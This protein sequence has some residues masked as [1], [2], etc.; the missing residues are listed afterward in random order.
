MEMVPT[1]RLR[2]LGLAAGVLVAIFDT[3]MAVLLGLSFEVNGQDATLF[4]G[5]FFGSS[6]AIGGF[7]IGLAMEG[8]RRARESAAIIREQAEALQATRA[9]LAQSE[10]LAALGQLASAIAH[11]VRNPLAIMRSAAQGMLEG[12]AA[13]DADTERSCSFIIEEIDRLSSVVTSLLAFARPPRL[14]R[15]RVAVDEVLGRAEVLAREEFA[16]RDVRITRAATAGLPELYGDPDLICQVLLGLVANAVDVVPPGGEIAL[17][18]SGDDRRVHL[19]VV[20]SGPGVPP[21]QRERI[22]EPFFTTRDGGTGLGLAVARQIAQAHGGN[23]TVGDRPGGGA[24]FVVGLPGRWRGRRGSMTPRILIVDDEARMAAV[25]ADALGRAGWSCETCSSGAEA[26]AALD[27]RG[28]DV[29]VTDWKMP[30]MDGVAL[31]ARIRERWPKLPVIM[32]TAYGNVQSAVAAMREGAFDYVIKPF[33]NEDLRAC[34][35]RALELTRLARENRYLRQEVETR[36]APERVVA[37]SPR[38][39]ELLDL[40]RRVA[41]SKATVLVQGESGTGKE[42]VARLLHYWSDRVGRPFVAVNCK[43]FAEGVLE[44]ELFG[45]EKGAFTGAAAARAGCFERASTGTLFLD[46]IGEVSED[47]QA[48]LLRVLQ[49]GEVLRVGGSTPKAVDVRVVAA[50]NRVLREEVAAGRFREDLFYRLN[51]IPIDIAPLRERREDVLPLADHFLARHASEAGRQLSFSEAASAA[52]LAHSWPGNVREL[53]NAIERGVVLAR[54]AAVE[55]EDLLLHEGAS[56]SATTAATAG[57]LQDAMDE[58]AAG[59]IRSALAS[60]D[61]NRAEAARALGIDRTTLYR[62][63]KRL[64]V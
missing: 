41:G 42:L 19:E 49:D 39:R 11:E 29:V 12:R 20:D 43:A 44:S 2:W 61:D 40:V 25:L 46:E 5:V 4:A 36:Y 32:V 18:A 37:E 55:P 50:T 27:A 17:G 60:A 64:G 9:R 26:L 62:L 10:K 1:T 47:F 15:R 52:L 59:R 22:F 54:D 48:K 63:M 58:A 24:A 51:V 56:T 38:S 14:E 57:T 31:L 7:L 13:P 28:A 35:A 34:V 16:D 8:Q 45:H 53:E 21:E 33:D 6:F 23:I 3:T 30:E